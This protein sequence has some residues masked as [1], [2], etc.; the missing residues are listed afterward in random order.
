VAPPKQ[1]IVFYLT[2]QTN[3][4]TK[5]KKKQG[6]IKDP[7]MKIAE[8]QHTPYQIAVGKTNYKVRLLTDACVRACV[9]ACQE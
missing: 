6:F 5:K 1:P 3:G 7:G 8:G 4:T 2:L 9:R